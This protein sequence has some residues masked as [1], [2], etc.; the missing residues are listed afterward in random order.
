MR[1]TIGSG[2]VVD[3]H[4]SIYCPNFGFRVHSQIPVVMTMQNLHNNMEK[5]PAELRRCDRAE[6]TPGK[7][8]ATTL[9][10]TARTLRETGTCLTANGFNL[11]P[12]LFTLSTS[13]P[14]HFINLSHLLSI[15]TGS[16]LSQH[17]WT[18]AASAHSIRRF[19]PHLSPDPPA[20]FDPP[21][22]TFT[23]LLEPPSTAF[24]SNASRSQV[25]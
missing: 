5:V 4:M 15:T 7:G 1:Q 8:P 22:R 6:T 25:H 3:A 9:T 21:S 13:P 18:R 11:K 12:F 10:T 23:T 14:H 19:W 17:P 20:S 24:C 16:Q 2:V